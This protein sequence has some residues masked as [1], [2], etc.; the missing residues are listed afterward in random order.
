MRKTASRVAFF[1]R[2]KLK[3]IMLLSKFLSDTRLLKLDFQ[4]LGLVAPNIVKKIDMTLISFSG[5]F[6]KTVISVRE[7]LVIL[8]TFDLI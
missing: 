2:T 1:K 8:D 5:G 3:L 4:S 7:L 6:L